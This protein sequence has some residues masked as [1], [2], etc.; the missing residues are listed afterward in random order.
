MLV[1]SQVADSGDISKVQDGDCADGNCLQVYRFIVI[2]KKTKTPSHSHPHF[3]SYSIAFVIVQVYDCS[4]G[5]LSSAAADSLFSG[6]HDSIACTKSTNISTSPPP[7][8]LSFNEVSSK[9]VP[10]QFPNG[11]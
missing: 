11:Y 3:L 4:H 5:C 6:S 10:L 1:S 2:M 9:G 8:S 7:S